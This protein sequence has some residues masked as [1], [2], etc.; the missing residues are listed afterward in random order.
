M[1]RARQPALAPLAAVVLAAGLALVVAIAAGRVQS[2]RVASAEAEARMAAALWEAGGGVPAVVGLLGERAT[3]LGAGDGGEGAGAYAY[4]A[5]ALEPAAWI[6]VAP[7]GA[8]G[9]LGALPGAA[10]AIA[11]AGAAIIA[12]WAAGRRRGPARS[13]YPGGIAL[14]SI[15]C[16][17]LAAATAGRWADRELRLL[18]AAT[19]AQGAQ[20]VE[21]ALAGGAEPARAARVARLPWASDGSL[22][23]ADGQW[24]M[25]SEV[26]AA[27]AAAP[28]RGSQPAG[29]PAGAPHTVEA[30][31]ATWHAARA[32]DIHLALLGYERTA[33]PALALAAAG[34]LATLLVVLALH[35]VQL[36]A[37]PRALRRTLAA[38]GLLAPAAALIL[39]FTL[40]PLVFSLWISLHEWRLIDPAPLFLG[41]DN[42]A[43]LLA[44]GEWWSAIG[45]TALFT[46][47]VPAAMAIALALA[48]LTRGSRRAMR[49]AR[50]ALFLPGITSVAAI[51]VVWKWLLSDRY[52]LLNRGLERVGLES[53]PW[54]T[55]PDTALISLMMIG[56]WMVLGYQMV[57]FQAG[58]AAIPR[59]WYDAARVDGAG[60]WQRFRHVTL[61]GLRHTLFFVLVTS[62]IGSFQVFGLVYVMTEGG[63]L[64]ATDV[65]VY[66]IY[67]EAWEFLQFGNA[68]AM[69]WMLFAVVFAATWLHFR[70]LDARRAHG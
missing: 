29:A 38:W 55:S 70:F 10:L 57:V 35:L 12:G 62:V 21:L 18:S 45:N 22:A 51:A 26:A 37:R 6:A 66:H 7:R 15:S 20:A 58:L 19:V 34:G 52:G 16:I 25:P 13:R 65:A 61:P 24:T 11:L 23:S 31:G 47:H 2:V 41:F 40:G 8:G 64:G 68:A 1:S 33:S 50:L 46:L 9:R 54:L 53:V 63:P 14:L 49:W 56:V 3:M 4:E 5:G 36:A 30:G 43:A 59:D 69:S 67:R 32:A 48:L 60:P 42:Y 28:D 44:D 17:A 39:A 27:I